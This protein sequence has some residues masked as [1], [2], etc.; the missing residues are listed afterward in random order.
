MH[1][2]RIT[3][4]KWQQTLDELSRIY[5]GA[6]VSLEILD[7]DFGAQSQILQQPLHGVTVD[8]GLI[9]MHFAKPG[10]GDH[11]CHPVTHPMELR[12]VA[13]DEGALVAL[14]IE[15]REGT[16]TLLHFTHPMLPELL[17]PAVE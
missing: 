11:L 13:T 15:E 4:D 3:H 9:E 2:M 7:E 10:G 1:T 8:H 5:E 12:M 16:H 6:L 17:D 14:E